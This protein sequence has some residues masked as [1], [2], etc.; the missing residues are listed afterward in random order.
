MKKFT[1]SLVTQALLLASLTSVSFAEGT[2]LPIIS[3]TEVFS[4]ETLGWYFD[5][6]FYQSTDYLDVYRALST[7]PDLDFTS[8]EPSFS[9]Y[10]AENRR[11]SAGNRAVIHEVLG[12]ITHENA[13]SDEKIYAIYNFLMYNFI[14]NDTTQES[15]APDHLQITYS[16]DL[17]TGIDRGTILLQT[18]T[19]GC[20]EF[21]SLLHR[22]LSTCGFPSFEVFGDYV[23]RDG[24]ELFHAFNRAKVDG[25]WYWYDVDVEGSTYRRGDVAS[26]LYYLYKKES[27]YWETNH[28]W[29]EEAVLEQETLID[30]TERLVSGEIFSYEFPTKVSF[31][32]VEFQ[33]GLPI[34]GYVDMDTI[35]NTETVMLLPFGDVMHFLGMDYRWNGETGCLEVTQGGTLIEFPV[36]SSSYW[37]NANQIPMA[38]PLKVIDGV[39]YISVDDVILIFNYEMNQTFYKENGVVKQSVLFEGGSVASQPDANFVPSTVTPTPE[40]EVTPPSTNESVEIQNYFTDVTPDDW[41]FQYV[42]EAA[43]LKA[44]SGYDDGTFK[45]EKSVTGTELWVMLSSAYFSERTALQEEGTC[46]FSVAS[47]AESYVNSVVGFGSVPTL[48]GVDVNSS[49]TR[50]VAAKIIANA[51]ENKGFNVDVE[52]KGYEQFPQEIQVVAYY[53]LMTGLTE[54]DFGENNSLNRAATAV[55]LTKMAKLEGIFADTVGPETKITQYSLAGQTVSDIL[56][57]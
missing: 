34:Y 30:N 1:R 32:Q 33:T 3:E 19:G 2:N 45:P 29:D 38:L 41:H 12:K 54:T 25:T 47:W 48:Y 27:E 26:P 53:N 57:N 40:P 10:E 55:I 8:T 39:D 14:R 15:P 36:G 22:F 56:G 5:F 46:L 18:G 23:N 37:K 35:S 50:G 9:Q 28:N 17:V 31:N 7:N 52:A 51:L 21:S 43:E 49:I 13:S 24:S 16:N 20:M 11:I 44:V 6:Y 4:H 42:Q